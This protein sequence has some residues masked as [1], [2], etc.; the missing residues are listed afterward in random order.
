MVLLRDMCSQQTAY[1]EKSQHMRD[2]H[3]DG[4]WT[5]KAGLRTLSQEQEVK[6]HWS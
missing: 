3:S 5:S 2:L 4:M 6:D 1:K